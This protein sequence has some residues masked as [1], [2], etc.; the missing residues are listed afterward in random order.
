M[1]H[2]IEKTVLKK[3]NKSEESHFLISKLTPNLL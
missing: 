2:R 1:E 3:K